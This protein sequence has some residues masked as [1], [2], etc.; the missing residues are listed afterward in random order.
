MDDIKRALLGDPVAAE[1]VTERGVLLPCPFCGRPGRLA[2]NGLNRRQ[3]NAPSSSGDFYTNWTAKCSWCMCKRG[4]ARTE[5]IFGNNGQLSI[6]GEDGRKK[7]ATS[8]NTRPAILTPEELEELERMEGETMKTYVPELLYS[9]ITERPDWPDIED[10]MKKLYGDSWEL[11][12]IR[13]PHF[14]EVPKKEG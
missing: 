5:F 12:P 3:S 10:Q 1:I 13:G 9:E 7:A 4:E 2:H 14:P 8:W 11:V 6:F